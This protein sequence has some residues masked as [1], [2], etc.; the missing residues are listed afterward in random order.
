ME[1]HHMVRL[2][3]WPL[4]VSTDKSTAEE[5]SPELNFASVFTAGSRTFSSPDAPI[6]ESLT[7]LVTTCC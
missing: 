4:V 7:M 3:E 6:E 5:E 2:P 1:A